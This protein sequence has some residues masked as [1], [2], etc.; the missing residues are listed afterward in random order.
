M[1]KIIIQYQ[2]FVMQQKIMLLDE[3]NK[4]MSTYTVEMEEIPDLVATLSKNYVNE[5]NFVGHKDFALQQEQEI[6]SKVNNENIKILF[7]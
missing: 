2:P 1:N 7:I 5:I 6:I 4:P 3:T